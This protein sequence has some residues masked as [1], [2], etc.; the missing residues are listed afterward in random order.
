MLHREIYVTAG[1][2]GASIYVFARAFDMPVNLAGFAGIL[3]AF[4]LRGLAVSRD[5]SLPAF[6]ARKD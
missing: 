1:F 5:W 2:V 6:R 3:A 4:A